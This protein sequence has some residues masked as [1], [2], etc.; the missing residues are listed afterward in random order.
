[1]TDY[2][3]A[4]KPRVLRRGDTVTQDLTIKPGA[5]ALM[6]TTPCCGVSYRLTLDEID[7]HLGARKPE[8]IRCGKVRNGRGNRRGAVGCEWPYKIVFRRETVAQIKATWKV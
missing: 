5:R 8:Y 3:M 1:M 2:T 7:W 4:T 6:I